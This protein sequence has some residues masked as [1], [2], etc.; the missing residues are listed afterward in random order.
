[1]IAI[2]C[3]PAAILSFMARG[4]DTKGLYIACIILGVLIG[5]LFPTAGGILGLIHQAVDQP[6]QE[7][8]K[9]E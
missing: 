7:E 9:A 8:P 1:M 6:K 4:K 5:T 2:L 3:I